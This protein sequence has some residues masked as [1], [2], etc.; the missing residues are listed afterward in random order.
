MVGSAAIKQGG[1]AN[2]KHTYFFLGGGASRKESGLW[3]IT[4]GNK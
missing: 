2:C 4:H 3:E 1:S